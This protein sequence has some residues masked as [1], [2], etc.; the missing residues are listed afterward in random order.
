MK[1]SARILITRLHNLTGVAGIRVPTDYSWC[2]R[3]RTTITANN[4][5]DIERYVLLLLLL[6]PRTRGCRLL[7][8][9]GRPRMPL[10]DSKRGNNFSLMVHKDSRVSMPIFAS[11]SVIRWIRFCSCFRVFRAL[12]LCQKIRVHS[13]FFFTLYVGNF[14]YSFRSI[15]FEFELSRMHA[16]FKDR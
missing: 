16:C 15:L 7:V 11:V 10:F 14:N 12:L 1:Q 9:N 5:D 4:A 8:A 13:Y 3:I 2:K 6:P